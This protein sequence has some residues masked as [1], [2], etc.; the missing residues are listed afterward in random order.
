M[1]IFGQLLVDIGLVF[2]HTDNRSGGSKKSHLFE[3][4]ESGGDQL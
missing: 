2:S 3:L 4:A 1:N